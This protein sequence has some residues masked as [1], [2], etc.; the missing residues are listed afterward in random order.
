MLT[1]EEKAYILSN[2][3]IPEHLV[4]LMTH[5]CGGE[6]FLI[7]DYF[8][9]I[10]KDWTILVGYPLKKKF[11]LDEF[12][13][14]I[15]N[16]KNQFRPRY[17]SLIASH[18]PHSVTAAGQEWGQDFYYT[19]NPR[20]P[21]MRS[22]VKRNLKKAGQHLTLERCSEMTDAHHE[23]MQ[24]FIASALPPDRVKALLFKMTDFVGNAESAFVLNTRDAKNKLAA[25]YVVDL[26]ADLFS[27]YIIGCYS[28]KNYSPGASDLLLYELIQISLE[29]QKRYIHLGLG[30]NDGIRRFKEKWGGKPT[31]SY[32]M[33]ELVLQK[34]SVWDVIK[35]LRQF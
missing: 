25:F 8:C 9:C 1:S 35:A 14:V 33:C 16:I 4:G 24:E 21:I 17:F 18:L 3:Y 34:P 10:K 26:E 19:L 12:E 6:P 15:E 31:R 27:N 22:S 7:E 2:A 11:I 23:L 30:V 28:K 20:K 32:Q 5:L 13:G 29:F